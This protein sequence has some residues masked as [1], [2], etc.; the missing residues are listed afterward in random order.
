MASPL[1]IKIALHYC[2]TP[3]DYSDGNGVHWSSPAVKAII[4]AFVSDGLLSNAGGRGG[5][6]YG[7]T[8]A[9]GVWVDAIC[10]VPKPV[11]KWIIP[12]VRRDLHEIAMGPARVR[13]TPLNGDDHV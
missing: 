7:K 9:L 13:V 8:E 11:Q 12:A 6:M 5:E 1:E 10:S 2:T 3:G 4:A